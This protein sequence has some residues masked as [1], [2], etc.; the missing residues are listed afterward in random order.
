MSRWVVARGLSRLGTLGRFLGLPAFG[1]IGFFALLRAVL[2]YLP[3]QESKKQYMYMFLY[4]ASYKAH[5]EG[6]TLRE[7]TNL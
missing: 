4:G 6:F 7:S 3:R 1:E 2:N 5:H